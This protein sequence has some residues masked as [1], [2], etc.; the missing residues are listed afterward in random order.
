M[1]QLKP[2][3]TIVCMKLKM[4]MSTNSRGSDIPEKKWSSLLF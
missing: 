3:S 2:V 1:F 4:L